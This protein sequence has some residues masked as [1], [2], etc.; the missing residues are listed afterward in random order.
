MTARI[1]DHVTSVLRQLELPFRV[2]SDH[3]LYTRAEFVAHYGKDKGE[4]R[5]RDA[6]G[7]LGCA[8][9]LVTEGGAILDPSARDALLVTLLPRI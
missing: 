9:T 8:L 6:E 5:W 3:N 2:A 1:G 4:F 7:L